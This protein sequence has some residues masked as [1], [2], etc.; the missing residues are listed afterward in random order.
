[1]KLVRFG[2]PG[3]E[4]PG[5]LVDD[6]TIL[7]V[8]TLVTDFDPRFF[9]EGGLPFLTAELAR[10]G[11]A[12]RLTRI[13]VADV[14]LGPP[15]ARP[16]KLLAAGVNYRTHSA[17]TGVQAPEKPVLFAK[18]TTAIVGPNDPIV[19][20]PGRAAVDF[21]VELAFVVGRR[22]KDATEADA[23]AA[24]AGY[25]IMND[26]SERQ[27]QKHGGLK[28][29][30]KGKSFDTFA[31]LG[32]F[33][34]TADEI[35]DPHALEIR[36]ELNG[37][38]MQHASTAEMIFPCP[39]LLAAASAGMTIEPGDVISTGT[40]EGVGFTRDPPRYLRSGD[41]LRLFVAGLGEQRSSVA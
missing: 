21:E 26:V 32:P 5:V 2:T 16:G 29:W 11:A 40:P 36:L 33:V 27:E 20:P 22:V 17:E 4:A 37:E 30:F 18:A 39:T 31:P 1:M 41:A 14:R 25:V 6:A 8:S 28:Q 7:D 10:Q 23:R 15:L 34:A 13:A 38:T 24:I 12:S 9:G 35:D 3:R 19:I